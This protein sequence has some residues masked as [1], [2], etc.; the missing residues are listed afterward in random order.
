MVAV[1]Q[2]HLGGVE[3]GKGILCVDRYSVYNFQVGAIEATELLS[4][5]SREGF[6]LAVSDIRF[7]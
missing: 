7:S 3:E 2:E 6:C 1:I 5:Y 4:E